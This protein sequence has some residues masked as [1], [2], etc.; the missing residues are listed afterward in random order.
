MPER[1]TK[2]AI[3]FKLNICY[4]IDIKGVI[5]H[6]VVYL[7]DKCK[8]YLSSAKYKVGLFI[9]ACS[10]YQY[11]QAAQSGNYRLKVTG[12]ILRMY[13]SAPPPFSFKLGRFTTL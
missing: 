11:R 3:A 4:I 12:L 13:P 2:K 5:A 10:S 1:W 8:A 9:F 6:K 7:P